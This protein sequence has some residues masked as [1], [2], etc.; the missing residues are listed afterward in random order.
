MN[1]SINANSDKGTFWRTLRL[2]LRRAICSTRFLLGVSMLL[3]CII[4]NA[5]ETAKNYNNAVFIGV[6]G[7]I[8]L[9]LNGEYSTGPVL[10]AISTIP[11]AFSYL[12]EKDCGF[13]Q[14]AKER[15]GATTYG[16]CKAVATA[17]SAFLMSVVAL[18]IYIGILSAI[19]IPH[20]ITRPLEVQNTYA[21]VAVTMGPGWY[22]V[23]EASHV[24]LVCSQAALFSLMVMSYVPN[25]YVG[26]LSPLIG[27]YMMECIQ[28]ILSNWISSP[29][30]SLVTPRR[31]FFQQPSQDPLFSYIWTVAMLIFMG[32]FFGVS[33]FIQQGKEHIE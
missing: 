20:A 2:E 4:I 16:V 27:F 31:L 21:Q 8:R 26:F 10:L 29:L 23:I 3:A 7:L 17:V 15:I 5:V 28:M 14:Q 18:G 32:T 30:W 6:T 11:Y 25:T 22:Y 1:T 13:A 33:F 12:T 24:G 19:G 9:G